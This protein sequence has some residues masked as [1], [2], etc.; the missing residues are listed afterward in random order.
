MLKV[1]LT[2]PP[3]SF[4]ETYPDFMFKSRKLG[5]GYGAIPGATAPLGTLYVAAVLRNDGHDVSFIDGVFYSEDEWFKKIKKLNPH[6]V[7]INTVSVFWEKTKRLSKKL[8]EEIPELKIGIGGA[9]VTG[10]GPSLLTE[11][12]S[13]SIDFLFLGESE[14]TTR[15]FLRSLESKKIDKLKSIK[16]KWGPS[17]VW[18]YSTVCWREK[19]KLRML[20]K[21]T[22]SKNLDELPFPARDLS[23]M[24]NYCPSIGFYKKKPHAT[25]WASRGCVFNCSFCTSKRIYRERSVG[26][27]MDEI[28]YLVSEYNIR[29]IFFYDN[30]IVYNRSRLETLCKK[31][32]DADMDLVW[33]AQTRVTDVDEK[34]LK[35]MRRAGC[36]R[37]CYGIE[38]PSSNFL[39]NIRKGINA[40]ST[41]RAIGITKK[42]GIEI[43]GAFIIGMPG[44]NIEHMKKTIDFACSLPLDYAKFNIFT[45]FPDSRDYHLL[46]DKGVKV[47]DKFTQHFVTFEF[48]GL[49]KEEIEKFVEESY[50]KFYS[51]PRYLLKRFL[52]TRSLSDLGRNFRGFTAFLIRN[53]KIEFI[54]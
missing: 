29:D 11:K 17:D 20:K 37:L 49:T 15:D 41:S 32:I 45:P 44:E 16:P 54:P 39:K 13:E 47:S 48:D 23:P 53:K 35:L 38:T 28:R 36:W 8:K 27:I 22:P 5:K 33:S 19:K 6:F 25:I 14:Y 46:K 30:N 51:R 52:M 9:H 1:V 31:L 40:N 50:W 24:G 3:Y 18:R 12:N 26:S 43:F 21:Q 10:I 42:A 7:G 34:I 4:E 2:I